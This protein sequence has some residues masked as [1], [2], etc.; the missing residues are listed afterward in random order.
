MDGQEAMAVAALLQFSEALQIN[1]RAAIK[2]NADLHKRF[3]PL[4]EMVN[5]R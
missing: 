1:I 2:E 3:M 4:A 5:I